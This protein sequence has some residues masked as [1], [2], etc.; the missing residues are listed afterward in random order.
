MHKTRILLATVIATVIG[1][2]FY[3]IYDQNNPHY[4]PIKQP[5][6]FFHHT[7]ADL[8]RAKSLG[9]KAGLLPP[10][11]REHRG[12]DID[13][14]SYA[15]LMSAFETAAA[16]ML[17]AY[18]AHELKAESDAESQYAL[19]GLLKECTFPTRI[20][21]QNDLD[22][23]MSDSQPPELTYPA[24]DFTIWFLER[25]ARCAEL[26]QY[27]AGTDLLEAYSTNMQLA[28]DNGHPMATLKS[29]PLDRV[30]SG[31]ISTDEIYST[32]A[33]AYNYSADKPEDRLEVL[34]A[35]LDILRPATTE[36]GPNIDYTALALN[37]IKQSLFD[38]EPVQAQRIVDFV[39]SEGRLPIE[40][41][42]L[43][44]KA[45]SFAQAMEDGDWSFLNGGDGT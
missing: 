34:D 14:A 23:A 39:T 15:N 19:T 18:K 2:G 6:V 41:T 40:A 42:M 26:N 35:A 17:E 22:L 37:R 3:G 9:D 36:H 12:A 8:N 31:E 13:Y 33:N 24:N 5:F 11:T 7:P 29:L 21:N 27:L 28:R 20:S 32:F 25:L 43:R 10:L 44:K 1:F 4:A 45:D 30:N 38:R 16:E